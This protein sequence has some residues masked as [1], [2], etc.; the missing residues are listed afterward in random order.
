MT[1]EREKPQDEEVEAHRRANAAQEELPADEGEARVRR[2]E[3][4]DE[5]EAHRWGRHSPTERA[6]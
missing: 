6:R 1:D 3:D 5:V 4:D 2:S